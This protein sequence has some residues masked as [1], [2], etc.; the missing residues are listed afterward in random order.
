[1]PGAGVLRASANRLEA[2]GGEAMKGKRLSAAAV[3]AAA[4][5]SAVL[6]AGC[7]NATESEPVGVS[8]EGHWSGEYSRPGVNDPITAVITQNGSNLFLRTSREDEG[9][10]LAGTISADRRVFMMDAAT[11]ETWSSL[12]QITETSFQ[13]HDYINNYTGFQSIV[14]RR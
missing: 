2:E 13:I 3:V 9:Q 1:M 5:L 4:V 12:G 10:F 6:I 8:L 7:E 11:G 14:L